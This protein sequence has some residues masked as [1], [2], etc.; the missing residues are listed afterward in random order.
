M[1][2]SKLTRIFS[3]GGTSQNPQLFRIYSPSRQIQI[4][5]FCENGKLQE[6]NADEQYHLASIGKMFTAVLILSFVEKQKLSL[7]DEVQ[8]YLRLPQT[9]PGWAHISRTKIQDLLG[10]SSGI[11]DYYLD[12]N[13]KGQNLFRLMVTEPNRFWSPMETIEWA[14][15]ELPFRIKVGSV[16][17]SDT[18][19]QLLGLILEAIEGR[20]LHQIYQEQIFDKCAMGSSYMPFYSKSMR[21]S[22][23]MIPLHYQ[24]QN[25]SLTRGISLSWGG[26]GVASTT[27]DQIRFFTALNRGDLIS[28]STLQKMKSFQ[29]MSFGIQYGLGLMRFSNVFMPKRFVIWGHSGS[30]GSYLYYNENTD[31]Y[32]A[33]TC[34]KVNGVVQPIIQI[35]RAI[36]AIS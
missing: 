12:K 16:H 35:L 13:S 22:D 20:P 3:G 6:S 33:G 31:T 24:G 5:S 34:N 30:I 14:A 19:Y 32:F 2:E 27:E 25:L 29:P 18:N 36:Q 4:A 15:R 21:E 23:A 11:P 1:N 9:S 28:E 8:K 26:G 10:H 17:Y 7:D